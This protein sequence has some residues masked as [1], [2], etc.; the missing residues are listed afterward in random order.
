MKKISKFMIYVEKGI[1][2]HKYR[3]NYDLLESERS[4]IIRFIKVFYKFL[5][6]FGSCGW[7]NYLL[8]QVFIRLAIMVD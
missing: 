6:S 7:V 4:W 8:S 1:S 2:T 3:R 5:D